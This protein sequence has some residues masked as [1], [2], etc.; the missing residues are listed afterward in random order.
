[1]HCSGF[2]VKVALEKVF[3]EG[4]VPASTGMQ[5]NVDGQSEIDDRLTV[6]MVV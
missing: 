1:M 6:N 4:C 5:V 2:A 3:G